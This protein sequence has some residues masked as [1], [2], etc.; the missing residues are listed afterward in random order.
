MMSSRR[1][2]KFAE[3]SSRTFGFFATDQGLKEIKQ[4]ADGIGP[5]KLYIV[6]MPPTDLVERAHREGLLVHT[7][8]FRNE[9]RRLVGDYLGNPVEEYPQFFDL[10]VDGV[11][12]DFADTAVASR[13]LFKMLNDPRFASCFTNGIGNHHFRRADSDDCFSL[14]EMVLK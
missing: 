3:L 6:S 5:W 8:T 4:Y 14:H 10:G 7:W 9:Q 1:A 11:F 13:V 12:S 2:F